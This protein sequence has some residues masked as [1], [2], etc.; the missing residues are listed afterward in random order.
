MNTKKKEFFFDNINRIK[1]VGKKTFKLSKNKKIEKIKDIIF[2]FPYS[3]TDRSKISKLDNL[4]IGNVNTIK[5]FVKKIYFPRIRNLPNKV[6]CEDDTGKIEI[7]YFNS[8]EG[9]LRKIFPINKQI[10][11]SG[12]VTFYKKKYQI[13]NPEY[14]TTIENKDYVAKN[15][16]KYSLTKGINEKKYRSI[17]EEIIKKIPLIN[18]WLDNDFINKH[19]LANWNEAIKKLH[20]S[21]DS[22]NNQ[23]NS[24]R[25]I[26]F[27]EICANLLSL[28]KNRKRIK[29]IKKAKSFNEIISNNILKHLPFRLTNAQ[30]KVLKEINKDLQ[31]ENKNV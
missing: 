20:I 26:A 30:A 5:V 14:V 4:E 23:S 3:D 13:T 28:S 9:Y 27:D 31:S 29:K 24:F 15:I 10:V 11:I 25:R 22:Q 21:K 8:R 6:I 1:G 12:K 17:S 18:D 2:N 19:N 16:P 7:I